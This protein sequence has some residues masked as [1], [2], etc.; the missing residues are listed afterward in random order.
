M[1]DP[2]RVKTEDHT[3]RQVCGNEEQAN[4]KSEETEDKSALVKSTEE[5]KDTSSQEKDK[6]E[7][8]PVCCKSC[9]QIWCFCPRKQIY[10][11][12]FINNV[13]F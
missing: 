6:Q 12:V 11:I 7:V 4:V 1:A 13:K 8:K 3:E 9:N 10:R 2:A 5:N